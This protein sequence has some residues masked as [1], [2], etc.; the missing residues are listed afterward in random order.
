[1]ANTISIMFS[2]ISLILDLLL[3]FVKRVMLFPTI[4][5][6]RL[7]WSVLVGLKC[8]LFVVVVNWSLLLLRWDLIWLPR[9]LLFS[10]RFRMLMS[11]M[12]RASGTFRR[13]RREVRL[14]WRVRV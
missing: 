13:W 5:R 10:I 6:L 3:D 8:L 1:M 14:F 7:F 12:G 2:T 11:K 9:A 4:W